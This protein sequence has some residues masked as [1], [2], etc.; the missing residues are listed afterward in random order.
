MA[1]RPSTTT[2][3]QS[4]LQFAEPEP[5]TVY[6]LCEV[7]GVSSNFIKKIP[8]EDARERGEVAAGSKPMQRLGELGEGGVPWQLHGFAAGGRFRLPLGRQAERR[9]LRQ[10]R[11]TA[12]RQGATVVSAA[13]KVVC[14]GRPGEFERRT[15]R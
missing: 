3:P 8:A 15:P 14:V 7:L 4:L 13:V 11:V 1:L 2:R 10:Q 6:T 9:R 12:E 5:L